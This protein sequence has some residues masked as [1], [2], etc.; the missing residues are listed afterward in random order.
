LKAYGEE[1]IEFLVRE[2]F[3]NRRADAAALAVDRIARIVR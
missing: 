2:L 1:D 3:Q